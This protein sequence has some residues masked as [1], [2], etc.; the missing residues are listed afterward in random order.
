MLNQG[1]LLALHSGVTPGIA[2][3]AV[4]DAAG[5]IWVGCGQ[6]KCPSGCPLALAPVFNRRRIEYLRHYVESLLGIVA[7]LPGASVDAQAPKGCQRGSVF[8]SG[9]KVGC[10]ARCPEWTWNH[11]P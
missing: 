3:G 4:W 8:Q 7:F 5:Q 1:S 2:H 11:F 6:G 10:E 9:Q